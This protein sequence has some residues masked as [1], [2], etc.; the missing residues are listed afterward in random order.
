MTTDKKI[1]LIHLAQKMGYNLPLSYFSSI[2][3][4]SSTEDI[5][6]FIQVMAKLQ[7]SLGHA[8]L[9]KSNSTYNGNTLDSLL[10]KV[11]VPDISAIVEKIKNNSSGTID[12]DGA[13]KDYLLENYGGSELD[14]IKTLT[15]YE[16]LPQQITQLQYAIFDQIARKISIDVRTELYNSYKYDSLYT[17][18]TS[19]SDST[20][21]DSNEIY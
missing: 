5:P 19:E 7:N 21:S 11:S 16:N 8:T 4:T 13:V 12:V 9:V 20:V 15:G 1:Q 14:V 10:R 6:S 3:S 18:D 2:D 17:S